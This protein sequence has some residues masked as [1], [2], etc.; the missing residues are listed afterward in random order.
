MA[1]LSQN[2]VKNLQINLQVLEIQ[3]TLSRINTKRITS[4]SFI[5][6]LLKTIGKKKIFKVT[7]E[8]GHIIGREI[9]IRISADC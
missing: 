2:L 6:K 1:E 9:P 4:R 7:R 3:Q 8:K 5:A